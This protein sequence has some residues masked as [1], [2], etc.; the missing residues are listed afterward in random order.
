MHAPLQSIAVRKKLN[1]ELG[2]EAVSIKKEGL[3]FQGPEQ[4][5]LNSILDHFRQGI[6]AHF[7]QDAGFMRA[8]G[9]GAQM[10]KVGNLGNRLATDQQGKY[11][12]FPV[13]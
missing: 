13:G 10:K 3:I 6:H 7:C 5:M 2:N 8:D 1:T 4:S 9:F 11:F 12:K